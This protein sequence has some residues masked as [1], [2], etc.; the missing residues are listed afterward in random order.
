MGCTCCSPKVDSLFVDDEEEKIIGS[1]G[2]GKSMFKKK[3]WTTLKTFS[4]KRNIR[5]HNLNIVFKKFLS[6]PE[7]NFGR[8]WSATSSCFQIGFYFSQSI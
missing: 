7:G 4:N 2:F 8:M 6:H 1:L 5:Q 3:E